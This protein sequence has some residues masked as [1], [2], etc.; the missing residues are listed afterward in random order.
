M[1]LPTGQDESLSGIS[2]GPNGTLSGAKAIVVQHGGSIA[3]A[4]AVG[5]GTTVTV[6]LPASADAVV[7]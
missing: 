1:V 4:S 5:A 3:I 7:P 2:A 6:T